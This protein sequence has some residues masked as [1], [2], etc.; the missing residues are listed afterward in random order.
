MPS[1]KWSKLLDIYE[2][3]LDDPRWRHLRRPGVNLVPGDGRE[4]AEDARVFVVGEAPGAQENGAKRPFV[5]PSGVVLNR[6]LESIGLARRNCFVTNVVKF[7]PPGNRTPIGSEI[8]AALDTLRA[9]WKV[10]QPTLTIAVGSPAQAALGQRNASHHGVLLPFGIVSG[11]WIVSVYHPAFGL[12]KK[13]A[14][15]WIEEE[16]KRLNEDLQEKGIKL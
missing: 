6:L 7:R 4:S 15:V 14:Q 16:W 3:L 13:Q 12:R 8:I 10:I 9:E 5:G 11:H 2:A 1:S